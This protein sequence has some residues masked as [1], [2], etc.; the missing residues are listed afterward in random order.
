MKLFNR[1]ITVMAVVVSAVSCK[2]EQ[3]E[4][5]DVDPHYYSL[6]K[7]S[8]KMNVVDRGGDN[9]RVDIIGDSAAVSKLV[10]WAVELNG[11]STEHYPLRLRLPLDIDDIRSDRDTINNFLYF[12]FSAVFD[13]MQNADLNGDGIFEGVPGTEFE[14]W[15]LD[16]IHPVVIAQY[17]T[18]LNR[19]ADPFVS[20]GEWPST[21]HFNSIYDTVGYI[22]QSQLDANR[23][24]LK[25]LFAEKQY[26]KMEEML[27]EGLFTIYT[28]TGEEYRE[29]E[30]LGLN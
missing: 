23:D 10:R 25:H 19:Y 16:I 12:N 26:K 20:W 2:T 18:I 14:G 3:N 24:T 13:F 28:C 17:D 11:V 30:K 22:P 15:L 4:P 8:V 9:R 6:Q 21:N 5:T 7:A 29:L 27:E 1:I